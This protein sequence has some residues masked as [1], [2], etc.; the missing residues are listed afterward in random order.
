MT[1]T[2]S[3]RTW[4]LLEALSPTKQKP[5][6]FCAVE[7]R[8]GWSEG[9]AAAHIAG[10]TGRPVAGTC[11]FDTEKKLKKGNNTAGTRSHL[12]LL[13]SSVPMKQELLPIQYPSISST[14]G[15]ARGLPTETACRAGNTGG[16]IR[17]SSQERPAKYGV[18][19]KDTG[20]I[21]M[22]RV[23]SREE[24]NSIRT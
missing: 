5:F 6:V 1:V 16:A 13:L 24:R 2:R 3:P 21:M 23:R 15:Y 9:F 14:G 4:V 20:I 19:S 17:V 11:M 7:K 22:Y 12:P 18:F 10:P 8:D